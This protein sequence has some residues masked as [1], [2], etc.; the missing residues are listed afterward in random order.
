MAISC[1]KNNVKYLILDADLSVFYAIALQRAYDAEDPAEMQDS[2]KRK[3]F[4]LRTKK[5][6]ARVVREEYTA[7]IPDFDPEIHNPEKVFA[8][9]CYRGLVLIL[10]GLKYGFFSSIYGARKSINA[11]K[12]G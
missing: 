6:L 12:F 3:N 11:H 2:Q 4:I 1:S 7:K 10:I 8:F 5:R 9:L